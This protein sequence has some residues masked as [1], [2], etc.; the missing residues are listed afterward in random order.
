MLHL[1]AVFHRCIS[2]LFFPAPLRTAITLVRSAGYIKKGIACLLKGRIQ[3][4]VL[5]ATAITVSMLRGDFNTAGSIMFLLGIGDTLDEWT[6]KK[7][8]GDLVRSMA[9]NVD[10]VWLQTDDG[11][12]LVPVSDVKVGADD[13]YSLLTLKRLSDALMDRIHGN[14]RKIIGFNFMLIC[15]GVAG[16][17]PPATSALLHNASTLLISLKSMTNLLDEK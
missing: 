7:S 16:I 6:H 2:K 3:V 1:Q 14:Y 12:V 5:D 17:L 11:D 13:L 9:L 10:K 4:P 8:V 15:L